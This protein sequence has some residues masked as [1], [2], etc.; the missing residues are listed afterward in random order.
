[1]EHLPNLPWQLSPGVLLTLSQQV[2]LLLPTPGLAQFPHRGS[3][4]GVCSQH[5][6]PS[7]ASVVGAGHVRNR[8]APKQ[9]GL[10]PVT[11]RGPMAVVLPATSRLRPAAGTNGITNN[12]FLQFLKTI[13][14][15]QSC[16]IYLHLKKFSELLL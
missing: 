11:S 9:P 10:L 16:N 14:V 3:F 1:M 8:N 2:A 4:L 7:L 15:V 12:P 13:E 5:L 6:P